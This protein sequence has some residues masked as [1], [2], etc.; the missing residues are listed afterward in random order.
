M[1]K[2]KIVVTDA[3]TISSDNSFFEPL[4]ALGDLELYDLSTP[5]QLK[6][7]I[8]DCEIIL[9]N[10]NVF[11]EENL[12]YAKNLKYIGLFATGYN[13]IDVSYTTQHGI[14]VCNAGSYSTNSVAQHTFALILNHFSKVREYGNF[15]EEGGWQ[16]SEVFSPFIYDMIELNGKTIGIVGYGNIG[17]AVAR[18][19]NAFNMNVLATNI[20]KKKDDNVEF[21]TFDTLL[22]KSDVIS[23]HCPLNSDSEKMF[24]LEAF[25]KCKKNA[26]FVNTARGG[27]VDEEALA[28]ALNSDLIAA[29]AIDCLTVEPMSGD[30]VLMKSK[31]IT[32]TPHVAWSMKETRERLLNIVCSNI[33]NFIAGN[34]T[35]VV[36]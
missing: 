32:F 1:K 25:K 20:S 27:I 30:N 18:L 31:N 4:K 34:P 13:N 16:K 2:I 11:N 12:Q 8:K 5:E 3:K 36:K 22:E 28:Y 26:L 9:C 15:C 7:R 17:K 23:V 21:V 33:N 24:N 35:N 14:T 10:K 19:G 6:E 29:A